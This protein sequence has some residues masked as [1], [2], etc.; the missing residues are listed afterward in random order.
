MHAKTTAEVGALPIE[1]AA[2]GITGLDE[3][4]AGGL[5]RGRTTL[6]VGGPGSGKTLLGMEFLINGALQFDEGGVFLAFEETANELATNVRS[7]GH[8]LESMINDKKLIVDHVRIERSEI[9][10]T[11]EYDLEGLFVRLAHAIESVGA[12]RL[13]IDTLE[14]LFGGLQDH[15]ILRAEFRRLFRWLNERRITTIVT[16]ERGPDRQMSRHGLEE[17]VSDCVIILDHRIEQQISTRRL[18]VV[19]Y[20]GSA[21]GA[22]EYPFL[23][24]E[25]GIE[26]FPVTSMGLDYRT[27]EGY[28]STGIAELDEALDG[29]G[30]PRGSSIL[31]TGAAGTGKSSM[32]ASL[33]DAACKRGERCLYFSMEESPAQIMRNM[34]SIGMELGQWVERKLLNINSSRPTLCGLE[35]HLAN[36]Y[37][38]V[39]EFTPD[40]VV[41]EPISGLGTVGTDIQVTAAL[42]RMLDFLK[43]RQITVLCTAL[44]SR[45]DDSA[46]SGVDVSSW[47]DAWMVLRTVEVSG[48]RKRS[49][50]IIKVR[51]MAH[52][53]R[54]HELKLTGN[55]IHL[56]PPRVLD[57]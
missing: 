6:V 52:S 49:L 8:D 45:T 24:D 53:D 2:T 5:P 38:A 55:G 54:V 42:T 57:Q 34:R 37:K 23:I 30:F 43:S 39:K 48:I 26:V 3:I 33:V 51:G 7:L 25:G 46:A 31:L 17:Y 27:P 18:R 50:S 44:V 21:H 1:K 35:M 47:M 11:G 28:I 41:I 15:G 29:R 12:R 14:V 36:I 40:V 13:V 10:E 19:K 9:E 56:V 32:A 20:R 16:G 4:T 22:D